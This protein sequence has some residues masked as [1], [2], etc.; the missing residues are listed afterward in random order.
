M[1]RSISPYQDMSVEVIRDSREIYSCFWIAQTP[2]W[3]TLMTTIFFFFPFHVNTVKAMNHQ[4]LNNPRAYIFTWMWYGK[5]YTQDPDQRLRCIDAR[6][7]CCNIDAIDL[8]NLRKLDSGYPS[9]E[10]SL[11]NC[12]S[13]LDLYLAKNERSSI[14]VVKSVLPLRS[15]NLTSKIYYNQL[16]IIWVTGKL[17]TRQ[18]NF[19]NPNKGQNCKQASYEFPTKS[20]CEA[21]N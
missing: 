10:S 11:A 12:I 2:P 9:R 4:L 20:N 13:P 21:R 8:W 6:G 18:Q 19:K 5:K 1:K 16:M 7:P 14:W 15:D 17:S 3:F